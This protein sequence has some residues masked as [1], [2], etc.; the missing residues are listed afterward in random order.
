MKKTVMIQVIS[1][2]EVDVSDVKDVLN[3]LGQQKLAKEIA[4]DNVDVISRDNKVKV[5]EDSIVFL[6]TADISAYLALDFLR[7]G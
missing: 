7:E 2:I 1:T 5:L 6:N 3:T 4:L